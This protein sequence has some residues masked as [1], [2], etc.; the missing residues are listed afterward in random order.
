MKKNK[1]IIAVFSVVSLVFSGFASVTIAEVYPSGV[2]ATLSIGE[3][4]DVDKTVET[5]EIP[6]KID[7]CLLEDETASFSD[8]IIHLQTA[9]SDIYD[10]VV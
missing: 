4:I 6:P 5:P 1:I 10:N 2:E 3:S 8:D 7:V 9:A